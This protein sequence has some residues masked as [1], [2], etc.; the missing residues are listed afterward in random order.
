MRIARIGT[1]LTPVLLCICLYAKTPAQEMTVTGKLTRAMAI[2]GE[3]TG[4]TIQLD[5]EAAI[6]GKQVNSIEVD[7]RKTKRLEKLENK[8][9]EAT[10]LLSHRQG[11]E[12]GERIVLVISSIQEAQAAVQVPGKTASFSLASSEWLLED[13]VGLGVID[14]IQA[15][16][17]FPEASKVAGNGS[18]NRFFGPAEVSGDAIKLGPLASSRMMCPEAVMNQ[19]MKYM[20]AL[21][22][23]EHFEWKDPYLLIYCKGFEKPL[24]FTRMTPSKPAGS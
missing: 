23:A 18:C 24:R 17:T 6:D 9:V 3:S 15:T 1:G 11:V 8:H 21:Q 22:T 12:T 5:S 13:L 2:G 4:W 7:S 10:G 19:E 16:L 20:N 14:N